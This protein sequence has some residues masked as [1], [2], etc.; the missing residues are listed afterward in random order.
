MA[1]RNIGSLQYKSFGLALQ[2]LVVL[3]K[4]GGTCPSCE[5]AKLMSSE[6]TLL[7]R[8]L[9]KLAKESILVTR[10]GR[11]GGYMLNKAADQLTL[12]EVY[13]ALEVG[14]A[15]HE[16]VSG[17]ACTNEFG[18]QMKT[19]FADILDEVDSGV[20]GVLKKYTVAD[21]AARAGY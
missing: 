6:P 18:R 2:A 14:E 20:L 13:R 15:R 7:R 12:A 21:I 9:A 16:A 3:T 1:K 8:I 10:E 5:I 4:E 11:D 19:A 17:T